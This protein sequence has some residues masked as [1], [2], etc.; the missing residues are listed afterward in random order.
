MLGG[1]PLWVTIN[2]VECDP[3]Y[4]AKLLRLAPS[5]RRTIT[6]PITRHSL[7]LWDRLKCRF[8]LQSLHNPLLSFL[9]NPS[10]YPAWSSPSS[11]P[12]WSTTDLFCAQTFFTSNSYSIPSSELFRYIQIKHFLTLC[13]PS[14]SSNL[15]F[16]QF[17]Q[18]CKSDPHKQESPKCTLTS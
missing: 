10:F 18:K 9:H 8:G 3:L 15:D 13:T 17:E 14:A 5:T 12:A 7:S 1:K 6:N 16:T 4:M 11:F 2:S